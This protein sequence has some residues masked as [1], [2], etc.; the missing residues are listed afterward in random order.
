[1]EHESKQRLGYL[2]ASTLLGLACASAAPIEGVVRPESGGALLESL[3]GPMPNFGPFDTYSDA[4]LAACSEILSMPNAT[5]GHAGALDDQLRWRISTEYCGWLYYTPDHKYEMSMLT[6]QSRPDVP[7]QRKSCEL[8]SRVDDQR[9]PPGSLKYIFALHNHPF[10]S[11]LSDED[12]HYIVEVG[13]R[14]GFEVETRAGKVWIAVVAFYSDTNQPGSPTCDGFF[15]Y[16]PLASQIRKWSN[17]GHSWSCEQIG[18][19]RWRD[20]STF[21]IEKKT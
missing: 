7:N 19:V 17:T 20:Q 10:G 14:H 4:L 9:Y 18:T 3:P 12:I 16:I 21:R 6:D 13:R 5:S 8:P 1:M 2:L 11:T 15:Q